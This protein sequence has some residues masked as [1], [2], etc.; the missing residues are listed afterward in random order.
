[1]NTPIINLNDK[2]DPNVYEIKNYHNSSSAFFRVYKGESDPVCNEI[3]KGKPWEANISNFLENN[4]L[5][6]SPS[7][8]LLSRC[9]R[10]RFPTQP[11]R[12]VSATRARVGGY[13]ELH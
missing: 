3:K 1:M 4:L 6:P 8:Q 13:F 5:T 2:I 12:A 9:Y 11:Y 10:W 7:K